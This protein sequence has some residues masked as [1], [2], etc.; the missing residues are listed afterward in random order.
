MARYTDKE[1]ID[2]LKNGSREILFYLQEKY[3]QPSRRYLRRKG[4]PEAET[5]V[6]FSRLLI[7]LMRDAQQRRIPVQIV[8]QSYLFNLLREYLSDFRQARRH[9]NSLP[10]ADPQLE[11][12]QVAASC[13][14]ILDG[15][16]RALLF[17]RYADQNNFEQ[18]AALFEFSNPVI[19]QY[20][21]GKAMKQLENIVRARFDGG[22]ETEYADSDLIFIDRYLEGQLSGLELKQFMDKLQ[23]DPQFREFV[24]FRNLLIDGIR[25]SADD[26]L[27]QD[28]VEEIGFRKPLIPA[29]LKMT[30]T[31]LFVMIMGLLLWN[32]IGVERKGEP[33][34]FSFRWLRK[35]VTEQK[36]K[37]SASVQRKTAIPSDTLKSAQDMNDNGYDSLSSVEANT[38]NAEDDSLFS[39]DG[40]EIVVKKDQLLGVHTVTV[41]EIGDKAG[42]RENLN[43]ED[44]TQ[45]AAGKL[46]PAAGLPEEP[47]AD[48]SSYTVEFWI[49]PVNYRGYRLMHNTVVLFGIDQ[50]EQARLFRMNR[51]LYLRSGAE[52]YKLIPSEDFQA[53]S[54]V[55]EPEVL[56]SLK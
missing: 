31:F 33:R 40:S 30:L 48:L 54:M 56:S 4:V 3:F 21:V 29:A 25:S 36:V 43:T 28:I 22:M 20:E 6:V 53:Y 42:L 18:I 50:P 16:P 2:G 55:R 35:P 46:N 45:A 39:A 13:V 37:S 7:R 32:Y 17:A 19:A 9:K 1:L 34:I 41:K 52:V 24:G 27:E 26:Q 11:R 5:P 23:S 10:E 14:S 51:Q 8:L 12:V 15:V 49:S 38:F 44:L 47:N